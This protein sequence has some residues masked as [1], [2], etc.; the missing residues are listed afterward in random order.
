MIA[1]DFTF[2][3]QADTYLEKI[4][5]FSK[6]VFYE[7]TF[8]TQ[9]NAITN[10]RVKILKERTIVACQPIT[11]AMRLSLP[12]STLKK[13]YPLY[14]LFPPVLVSSSVDAVAH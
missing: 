14:V 10:N 12:H 9:K 13:A 4:I 3:A 11:R 2:D 5:F 8:F 7:V 6:K 1:P